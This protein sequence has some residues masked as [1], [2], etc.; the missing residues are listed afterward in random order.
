[1]TRVFS[2]TF[3][4][5]PI[6][7]LLLKTDS[8][9]EKEWE[10]IIENKDYYYPSLM[11]KAVDGGYIIVGFTDK[12]WIGKPV[13]ERND[14]DVFLIKVDSG[15]EKLWEKTYGIGDYGWRSDFALSCEQTLDGE[16]IIT[17]FANISD[18]GICDIFLLKTDLEGNEEWRKTFHFQNWDWAYSVKQTAD[19]GYVIVGGADNG[20]STSKEIYIIKTDFRGNLVWSQVI[21]EEDADET[22]YL[23]QQTVDGG[24]IILGE[25]EKNGNLYIWLIKLSPEFPKDE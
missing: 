7:I 4:N 17:G 14:Y 19:G 16:Y 6:N 24:Y 8:N 10:K 9:G 2:Q 23:V 21:G 15:G 13:K 11:Q 18:G 12:N 20:S 5:R 22:G 25:K 3:S 1:M